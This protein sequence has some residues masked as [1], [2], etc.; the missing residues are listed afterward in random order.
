MAVVVGAAVAGLWRVRNDDARI[1][2]HGARFVNDD[3]VDVHLAQL[4][5]LADHFRDAQQHLLQRFHVDGAGAAPLAQ[6]FSDAR[7][8]YQAA[9]Q[10]LVERRQLHG[11]V[12]D[13]L[14][15]GAAG[16]EGDHRAERLVGDEAD[17]DLAAAPGTRHVLHR[18]AVDAGVRLQPCHVL[19]H[20]VISVAHAGGVQDVEH[21]AFHV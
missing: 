15:H 10:K 18:D 17:A 11:A 4:R 7:A 9:R 5:Q 3:G 20:V 14:D 2:R 12:V 21:H 6:C 13:Q 8:L 19:H 1:D 16:A